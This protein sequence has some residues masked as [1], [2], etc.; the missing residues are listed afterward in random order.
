MTVS[1]RTE[2][3]IVVPNG[4]INCDVAIIWFHKTFR[5]HA[6]LAFPRKDKI[7]GFYM[8]NRLKNEPKSLKNVIQDKIE[9]AKG[10][11]KAI[12][13]QPLNVTPE[14]KRKIK[15]ITKQETLACYTCMHGVSKVLELAGVITIPSFINQ[16]PE[17]ALTY[18]SHLQQK[19]SKVLM[20][21]KTFGKLGILN[22]SSVIG[23][24]QQAFF[25][26]M[27]SMLAVTLMRLAVPSIGYG[28][29]SHTLLASLFLLTLYKIHSVV[30]SAFH[31]LI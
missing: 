8:G 24:T 19:G 5:S 7:V 2:N 20:E 14:Q 30:N 23:K 3:Q 9:G 13:V 17:L 16:L 10:V 25:A 18:L 1:C 21:Q 6:A 29:L 27:I 22:N 28:W 15:K 31:R 26:A 11:C 4:E 12:T